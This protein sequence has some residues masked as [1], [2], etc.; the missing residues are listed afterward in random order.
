MDKYRFIQLALILLLSCPTILQAQNSSQTNSIENRLQYDIKILASDSLEG[1]EA[2]KDGEKMAA[3]FIAKRMAEIGLEP[4]GSKTGSYLSEFRINYP[5]IFKEAS[6]QVNDIKFKHIEEFG[7]CDLSAAGKVQAPFIN[8]SNKTKS[9]TDFYGT[10]PQNVMG[11]IVVFDIASVGKQAGSEERIAAIFDRVK[12]I[13]DWGGVGVILHNTSRKAE[14]DV[15]FG[16]P[17]TESLPI[18][19][20]YLA[21]LPYNKIHRLKS[22]NCSI[23]VQIDR[24]V[25]QPVNVLGYIDNKA[26]KT[27]LIGA[28]FDHVGITRSRKS[29][30][31]TPMIHNGADDNASG[32]A[33]LLELVR[34]AVNNESL[35]Y[36][37][38][39]AAFSAEEKGLFGSKAYCSRNCINHDSIT[40]M[41]N[42]DMVGRLGC[43]GDTLKALGVASSAV[44]SSLLD[45]IPHPDF[46]LKKLKGAPAFSDH[47]PFLKKGIPVMYFT[48]GLHP[49]YH[50]H[51]DDIERINFKGMVEI[52]TF[53]RQF[54]LSAESLPSIDFQKINAV[55]QTNAY[56]KVF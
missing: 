37:Y 53:V 40:Y 14:E 31:K 51:L 49:E 48:T 26:K 9:S 52:T 30:D 8:L 22:G 21:R 38:I 3:E 25:S 55:Q 24:S 36:N 50:T 10:N 39:F 23:E 32:T 54:L 11:K 41:L 42:L 56:F 16:S 35:K 45:S 2:G 28:H 44:W 46:D 47:A 4:G 12:A 19:V 15:L 1:R 43:E 7:A 13:Y 5:V 33:M 34:W 27:V 29:E 6:L 20:V 18:P 17:F